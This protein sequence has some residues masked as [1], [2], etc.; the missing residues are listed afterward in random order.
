MGKGTKIGIGV[1][2]AVA[3]VVALG[4]VGAS[5]QTNTVSNTETS[6]PENTSPAVAETNSQSPIQE[7][8]TTTPSVQETPAP[9]TEN[10][11]AS[12]V[13]GIRDLN[14]QG[15]GKT[16]GSYTVV[17]SL[18][19][20]NQQEISADGRAHL[21]IRDERNV[22]LY[23]GTFTVRSSDFEIYQYV[24]TGAD[25]LGYGVTIATS[26][27]DKGIGDGTAE[28]TF[29]DTAG[30]SFTATHNFVSIPEYTDEEIQAMYE[31]EYM[32]SA[33]PIDLI[34]SD[35]DANLNIEVLRS[36]YYTHYTGFSQE[37]LFRVDLGVENIGKTTT[38]MY[39][40]DSAIFA[41]G[42]KYDISFYS[43]FDGQDIFAGTT[44]E[45]YLLFEAPT[46]LDSIDKITIGDDY[47][48]D[49]SV[50]QAYTTTEFY[51]NEYMNSSIE[52]N[53]KE[54]IHPFEITLARVGVYSY[55][56][57]STGHTAFRADFKIKNI[58]GSSEYVPSSFYL[59][60][61]GKQ[62]ESS[63]GGTL[64]YT[65]LQPNSIIEGYVLFDDFDGD[66]NTIQVIAKKFSYPEDIVWEYTVELS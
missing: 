23:S 4:A 58:S 52:V 7:E 8:S 47:I 25:F 57:F 51:E 43:S 34:L 22:E 20:N 46:G 38:D 2:I 55:E 26:S 12:T 45:G 61:D 65:E 3:I 33:T 53:D 30:K 28:L 59:L 10:I 1:G 5:M 24:F 13:A 42:N 15:D 40:F 49:L 62:Y 66:A 31:E 11:K 21:V 37:T 63:Y 48:F 16:D 27:V 19:D 29:T 36:G 14:V 39:T 60:A 6:A 44:R 41:S 32:E 54:T 35:S 18:L 56:Q 64:D 50:N 9:T 17:F